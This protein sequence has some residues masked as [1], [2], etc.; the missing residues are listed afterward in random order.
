MSDLPLSIQSFTSLKCLDIS[1][2]KL[3]KKTLPAFLASLTSLENLVADGCDL[4]SLH[5]PLSTLSS[6][7]T[8]SVQNNQLK[9]LPSWFSQLESLRDLRL[10]GNP[11]YG[12]FADLA[13]PLLRGSLSS[14]SRVSSVTSLT[15]SMFQPQSSQPP[16]TQGSPLLS[17][18]ILPLSESSSPS[19]FFA[20]PQPSPMEEPSL[21]ASL[22]ERVHSTTASPALHAST[23][24]GFFHGQPSSSSQAGLRKMRSSSD[25]KGTSAAHAGLQVNTKAFRNS[26]YADLPSPIR[27]T[28]TREDSAPAAPQTAPTTT[29]ATSRPLSPPVAPPA[30]SASTPRSPPPPAQPAAVKKKSSFF[31]KMG[32]FGRS[33][34]NSS[35]SNQRPDVGSMAFS[36]DTPPPLP[37]KPEV[38]ASI[39][40]S[41]PASAPP[42]RAEPP[43]LSR[44]QSASSMGSSQTQ[45][46]LEQTPPAH[47]RN[48]IVAL[49]EE[50]SE[51]EEI[52]DQSFGQASLVMS[53]EQ[54]RVAGLQALMAYLRDLDD[55]M[56]RDT[57]PLHPAE[58][59]PAMS[60][61]NTCSR[62]SAQDQSEADRCKSPDPDQSLDSP[63]SMGSGKLKVD[64]AKRESVLNEIVATERSYVA[65][66]QEL[67]DIY[68]LPSGQAIKSATSNGKESIIPT[69]ERKAVFSN[70]EN[71]LQFHKSA[72]LP[73]LE[74]ALAPLRSMRQSLASVPEA[75]GALLTSVA[76]ELARVFVRHGAFLKMYH[77]FVRTVPQCTD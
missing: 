52:F 12:I 5:H 70:I 22:R 36:D 15:Q 35:K 45:M 25:V 33:R 9:T 10:D 17:A 28:V 77:M 57:L 29:T 16:S 14:R 63:L 53:P 21:S 34:K 66:L 62:T 37:D 4:F 13:K 2:N 39:T 30:A 58:G 41:P 7:R 73:D 1:H 76:E 3:N 18:S 54:Q 75:F 65:G 27:P 55:L 72:F 26:A 31:K 8:L 48:G 11:L 51:A 6:L 46:R 60:R 44:P 19:P 67:V 59:R 61:R 23:N 47:V 49:S 20:S 50:D 64:L 40:P 32:S 68:V 74:A 71:L 42:T 43:A 69:G 24:Q 38:S 56:P